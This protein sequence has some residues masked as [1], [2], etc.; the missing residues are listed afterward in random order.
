MKV[1]TFNLVFN[2][3]K[4]KLKYDETALVQLEV[5]YDKRR[6]Y[7]KTGVYLKK[8]E[9]N[10]RS[11]RVMKRADCE[12]LNKV[13]E[14]ILSFCNS[15]HSNLLVR[16]VQF[17]HESF[18]EAFDGIEMNKTFVDFWKTEIEERQDIEPSTRKSHNVFRE[19][20]IKFGKLN[21]WADI[22]LE[23][24]KAYDSW[25][26]TVGKEGEPYSDETVCSTHANLKAYI[27]RALD[28]RKISETPY[29]RFEIEDPVNE[30]EKFLTEGELKALEEKVFPM[31]RTERVK[32]CFLFSCYTGLAYGDAYDLT[33]D[34]LIFDHDIYWIR[35]ERGKTNN[36]ISVPLM[37]KAYAIIEK[38]RGK[39][40][41]GKLLPYLTN[42]RMNGYLKEIAAGCGIKKELTTHVA[43]HTFGTTV[44]LGN[45]I[46]LETVSKMMAH[47]SIKTTQIYAKVIDKKIKAE[48]DQLKD[49]I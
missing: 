16:K 18:S 19:R 27:Q 10:D 3:K 12:D 23:N 7:H 6:T 14:R 47:S 28:L 48:M 29:D 4:K 45:G 40:K 43:R 15:Y 33:E 37:P 2:R 41:P 13:L 30:K 26:R 20:A 35:R 24:I 46:P 36:R 11:C 49:L 1:P 22:N 9:W 8:D 34:D 17:S 32:D 5:Y 38:Y 44:T 21:E 42:Q 25:L 39:V 31:E